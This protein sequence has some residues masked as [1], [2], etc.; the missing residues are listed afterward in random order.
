MVNVALTTK[1][2]RRPAGRTG[3]QAGERIVDDI[4]DEFT[5]W[6][7]QGRR[8]MARQWCQQDLSMSYVHALALLQAKGSLPMSRLA[9]HMNVSLPN[10][11][12]I[13]GRME[14]RGLVE[15]THD[16]RDRRVVMVRLTDAGAAA[17]EEADDARRRRLSRI[18]GELT[19][20]QRT[21]CLQT[22]REMREAAERVEPLA[23]AD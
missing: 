3:S 20:E 23:D 17:M 1:H 4:L 12:G 6:I 22:L 5:F 14:E 18:V 2:A 11:T 13:V 21:R 15:R 8:A 16:Q 19:P 7:V 9:E 10:A